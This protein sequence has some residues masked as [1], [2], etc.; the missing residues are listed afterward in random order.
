LALGAS[1]I[2]YLFANPNLSVR[3]M[4]S[5]DMLIALSLAAFF[6]LGVYFLSYYFAES[7]KQTEAAAASKLDAQEILKKILQ[8]PGDPPDWTD[9]N[10]INSLGLADPELPGM[11]DPRKLVAL[12]AASGV[13]PETVCRIRAAGKDYPVTKVGYGIYVWG[14]PTPT[15]IDPSVYERILRSLFGE[16]WNKYDIELRIKP[17]LNIILELSG[18]QV[19]IK[20]HPPGVYSYDV[21]YVYWGADSPVYQGPRG[22]IIRG[23][24]LWTETKGGGK[25]QMITY[26][27]RIDLENTG[28]SDATIESVQVGSYTFTPKPNE[29]TVKAGCT[30]SITRS[31]N[32]NPCGSNCIAT[33]TFR[34]SSG[35]FT[36]NRAVDKTP[37]GEFS[38]GCAKNKPSGDLDIAPDMA[39]TSGET[40]VDEE[41][42]EYGTGAVPVPGNLKFAFVYVRGVMLRGV[43]YTYWGAGDISIVGLVA[44]PSQGVYVVHS[45]LIQ[46]VGQ[47]ASLCGCDNPGVS[48]LGLRYLG[49]FLGGQ[50]APLLQN[51]RL[52]PASQLNLGEL[53]DS[54]GKEKGGCLIP[55]DKIG[56]AKFLIAAVSRNSQG[57]P[58]KCG[59]IPQNDVI[60]MPL[61]GGLPPLYEIDFATWRRWVGSRPE[62]L[63]V[64]HA[65]AVADAGE[66]TYVV[67]LWVFRYP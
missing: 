48:A 13:A 57:E 47:G 67:D 20:V 18:D 16:D 14:A 29:K 52:N 12:A 17:A 4:E 28:S 50:S 56:R 19:S 63:A 27:I 51:V 65:S 30:A 45:K 49:V 59:G 8:S 24:Y 43:N 25:N 39:C 33:V 64:S 6:M 9:V 36:V 1:T 40:R 7:S 10:Q 58:P 21:C 38:A 32:Y 37:P 3:G 26:N 5:I 54:S 15:S 42:R 34:N 22:L 31:I 55:W 11:L 62:A 23:A 60:V 41:H 66:I 2:K 44:H 35:T 53:C 61:A 46:N